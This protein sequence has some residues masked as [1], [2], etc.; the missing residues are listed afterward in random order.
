MAEDT[1]L[2]P[3]AEF[4]STAVKALEEADATANLDA[5]KQPSPVCKALF[6]QNQSETADETK[7][8]LA[9]DLSQPCNVA[10]PTSGVQVNNA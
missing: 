6:G 2:P 8:L 9:A 5:T 3:S 7:V 4:C 10:E 1:F